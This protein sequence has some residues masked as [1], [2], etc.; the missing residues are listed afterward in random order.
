MR[1]RLHRMNTA[2][3]EDPRIAEKKHKDC[4]KKNDSTGTGPRVAV[5][6]VTALGVGDAPGSE[7]V[8][9]GCRRHEIQ[10]M[11]Q[12][13]TLAIL[14]LRTHS[15]KPDRDKSLSFRRWSTAG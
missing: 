2:L 3:D 12:P 14:K 8:R 5:R 13:M 6:G 10:L 7:V 4:R 9:L 15:A 1:V 11:L